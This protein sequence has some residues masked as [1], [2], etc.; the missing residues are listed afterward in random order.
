MAIFVWLCAPCDID[1]G[2]GLRNVQN[3]WA[4]TKTLIE[5][6]IDLENSLI[7]VGKKNGVLFCITNA[8]IAGGIS[9]AIYLLIQ[10]Y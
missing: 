5:F 3:S 4:S 7:E 2:R 8:T 9:L 10:A 6:P 1:W